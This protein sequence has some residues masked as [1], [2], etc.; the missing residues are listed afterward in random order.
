VKV[1]NLQG[2]TFNK[3]FSKLG[4][5]ADKLDQDISQL[6]DLMIKRVKDEMDLG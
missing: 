3:S 1:V 5:K 2:A 6:G 4:T